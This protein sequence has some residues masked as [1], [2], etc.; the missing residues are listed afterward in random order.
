MLRLIFPSSEF[1]DIPQGEVDHPEGTYLICDNILMNIICIVR[2]IDLRYHL[3]MN[4]TKKYAKIPDDTAIFVIHYS[5]NA[6]SGDNVLHQPG[7]PQSDNIVRNNFPIYMKLRSDLDIFIQYLKETYGDSLGLITTIYYRPPFN[8]YAS[9]TD[10]LSI[11]LD[12][13]KFDEPK[14]SDQSKQIDQP[15]P[16]VDEPK[17]K[18]KEHPKFDEQKQLDALKRKDEITMQNLAFLDE[19]IARMQD[20]I[21]EIEAKCSNLT[22]DL[23]V[24]QDAVVKKV[25]EYKGIK[26]MIDMHQEDIVETT[27]ELQQYNAHNGVNNAGI[28]QLTESL[29]QMKQA[30]AVA[31]INYEELGNQIRVD[32][33]YT[34]KLIDWIGDHRDELIVKREELEQL[35][36]KYIYI[37]SNV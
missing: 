29:E 24:K 22:R 28:K 11:Q 21:A 36:E 17:Q 27:R 23:M 9:L 1:K 30:V 16:T 10:P 18:Q 2:N 3:L 34:S 5:Y 13:P 33:E 15:K 14:Q 6:N 35:R 25:E 32:N 26:S 19:Q 31:T 8:N 7:Y 4:R 20:N 12:I 37:M